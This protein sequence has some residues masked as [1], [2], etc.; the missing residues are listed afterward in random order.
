[1]SEKNKQKKLKLG[2]YQHYKRKGKYLVLGKAKNTETEE[3]LVVYIPLYFDEEYKGPKMF[4]RPFDMFMEDVK[5]DNGE[6]VPRFKYL[7]DEI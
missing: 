3:I 5:D 7:G 6:I 4:V 1:M 2:I